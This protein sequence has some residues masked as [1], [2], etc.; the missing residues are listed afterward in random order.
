[1]SK[2][3]KLNHIALYAKG[4]YKRSDNIW[5]DLKKCLSCDGYSGD[6]M[7][8]YDVVTVILIAFEEMPIKR[9]YHSL[10]EVLDGISPQRCWTRG[11]YYKDNKEEYDMQEATVRY[12]L[13]C[14][15][16]TGRDE[17]ME[18]TGPDYVKCLPP[19]DERV[20]NMVLEFFPKA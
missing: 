17:G 13:S 19:K 9:Y 6:I 3:F 16:E 10:R 1:M 18:L 12:C 11:Y 20:E 15:M 7:S 14:F 4:W 8:K 5:E 2:T